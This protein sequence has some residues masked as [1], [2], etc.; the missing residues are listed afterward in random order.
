MPSEKVICYDPAE[1]K[2]K[3]FPLELFEKV[4]KSAD[5][6]TL[7]L[8]HL[9][10]TIV[11][12]I[13]EEHE[14]PSREGGEPNEV[15]HSKVGVSTSVRKAK[16]NHIVA[17]L[18]L[19]SLPLAVKLQRHLHIKSKNLHKLRVGSLQPLLQASADAMMDE[20]KE[21]RWSRG[22]LRLSAA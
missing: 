18:Y 2:V 11:V 6:Q 8:P 12:Y 22:I 5:Y 13:D 14:G 21:S 9:S 3:V 19:R 20:K 16:D 1:Q 17:V 15:Q 4:A 7:D 10:H